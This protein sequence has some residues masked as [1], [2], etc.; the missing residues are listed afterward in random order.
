MRPGLCCGRAGENG[1]LASGQPT[2][3][4][5]CRWQPAALVTLYFTND[6]GEPAEAKVEKAWHAKNVLAAPNAVS[7]QLD[8]KPDVEVKKENIPDD[9]HR[10]THAKPV[11]KQADTSQPVV[12][13]TVVAEG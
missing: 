11:D 5:I 7:L 3:R 8:D 4:V 13:Q 10:T 1:T 6:S 9:Q 12:V 2:L